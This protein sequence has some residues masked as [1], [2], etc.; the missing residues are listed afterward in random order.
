M[1]PLSTTDY[2]GQN[3]NTGQQPCARI[4]AIFMILS[5][6]IDP[7]E[8]GPD[9]GYCNGRAMKCFELPRGGNIT[10]S[11]VGRSDRG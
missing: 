5:H 8:A 2:L 6:A 11:A 1:R 7:L 3:E 4:L 9:H 10:H